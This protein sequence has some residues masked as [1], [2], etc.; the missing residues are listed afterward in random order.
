LAKPMKPPVG[1]R[2]ERQP[3]PLALE[4]V[5]RVEQSGVRMREETVEEFDAR[6]EAWRASEP[7]RRGRAWAAWAASE[8]GV[9]DLVED[10]SAC[11]LEGLTIDEYVACLQA[12]LPGRVHGFDPSIEPDRRTPIRSYRVDKYG[13]PVLSEEYVRCLRRR[14][15]LGMAMHRREDFPRLPPDS[16]LE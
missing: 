15:R 7:P 3:D 13:E 4:L 16:K 1:L 11:D 6:L 2:D 8:P 12:V 5:E 9:D 14:V 10:R